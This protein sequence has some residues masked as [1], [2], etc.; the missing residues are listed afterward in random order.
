MNKG[1]LT[2]QGYGINDK[3]G[4]RKGPTEKMEIAKGLITTS[5]LVVP[6]YYG[7]YVSY[8][9]KDE[10]V[11][12]WTPD[13]ELEPTNVNFYFLQGSSVLR[14]SEKKSERGQFF[15][16]F[17][18]EKNVTR[19]VSITGTHSPEGSERI[20][21]NLSKNRAEIIEEYYRQMMDRYDYMGAADEIKFVLKPVIEDWTAFQS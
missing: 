21:S 13:E 3:N 18:A 16:A 2:V 12:G 11:D 15:Q 8:D 6:A 4:K 10:T 1:S 17:I 7:A 9:Y 19:T 20:N 5:K 14:S